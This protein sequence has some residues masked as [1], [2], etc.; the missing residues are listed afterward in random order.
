MLRKL[1]D[2][3]ARATDSIDRRDAA[4]GI[5]CALLFHGGQQIY[6]GSGYVIVGAVL[7]A[8]AVLVR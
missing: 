1:R 5:G 2:A 4:F 7:V 8:V 6:A 3:L